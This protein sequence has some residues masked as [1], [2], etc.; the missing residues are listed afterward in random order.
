MEGN[1]ICWCRPQDLP[2]EKIASGKFAVPLIIIH[3]DKDGNQPKDLTGI[4]KP[5]VADIN[6]LADTG[7]PCSLPAASFVLG[8]TT[9]CSFN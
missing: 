1:I 7:L 5:L 2:Q 8:F 3:A 6:R 4:L 9:L